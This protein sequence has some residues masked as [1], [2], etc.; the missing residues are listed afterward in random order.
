MKP[1]KGQFTIWY[2]S[3]GNEQL[4]YVP[5]FVAET[6]SDIWMAETK[7]AKDMTAADVLAKQEAALSWCRHA[8][9]HAHAHCRKPW[10]YALIPHDA[11]RENMDLKVL[12]TQYAP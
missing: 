4:E 9:D 1:A 11:V 12:L 10:R 2:R 7:A 6:D 5:D 3:A 8:S